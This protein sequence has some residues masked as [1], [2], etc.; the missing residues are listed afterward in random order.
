M[1]WTG[2]LNPAIGATGVLTLGVLLIYFGQL[3]PVR[4]V[5]RITRAKDEEITLWKA[6]YDRS[7]AAHV[8][9]DRQ[10]AALMD[11]GRTTTHVLE[12]MHRATLDPGGT[13]HEVAVP[14]EG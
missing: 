12:A 1:D 9:K 4:I 14:E 6:A 3:I 10:I 2:F 5:N 11:A 8:L 13:G 7:E